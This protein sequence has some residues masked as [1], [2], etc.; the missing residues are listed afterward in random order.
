[1]AGAGQ[2]AAHVPQSFAD[3]AEGRLVFKGCKS[4]LGK[5]RGKMDTRQ[6]CKCLLRTPSQHAQMC[7]TVGSKGE[8]NELSLPSQ[9]LLVTGKSPDNRDRFPT[10]KTA[11]VIDWH[12]PFC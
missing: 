7:S 3:R 8:T 10:R 6:K 5:Q 12:F 2:A 9:A 1:M 4:Q 11:P